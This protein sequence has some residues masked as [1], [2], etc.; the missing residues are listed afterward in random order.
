MKDEKK[1]ESGPTAILLVV[2]V[3]AF[4][5]LGMWGEIISIVIGFVALGWSKRHQGPFP[6]DN[7]KE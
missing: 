6:T 4:Y 2:V 3:A 1:D 7:S 5:F